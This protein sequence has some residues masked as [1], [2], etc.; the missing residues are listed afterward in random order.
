M[1]EMLKARA[2]RKSIRIWCAAGSTGQEPIFA[3]MSPEG[4]RARVLAGWRVEII[5]NRHVHEVLEQ[6]KSGIYSRSRSARPSDSNGV[7]YFK[8][9]GELGR[10]ARSCA[11]MGQHGS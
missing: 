4:D 5:A 10:S 9:N 11:E 3:A 2:T 8:Q 7:K 6:S 1:P